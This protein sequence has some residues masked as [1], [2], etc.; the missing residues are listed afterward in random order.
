[1]GVVLEYSLYTGRG[2]VIVKKND[3]ILYNTTN[4]SRFEYSR[5]EY[6]LKMAFS[7]DSLS[8]NF[9]VGDVISVVDTTCNAYLNGIRFVVESIGL[10][11]LIARN[12]LGHKIEDFHSTCLTSGL[13]IKLTSHVKRLAQG[14][15]Q[16]NESDGK[17]HFRVHQFN[18]PF[19]PDD[20]VIVR[21]VVGN[22]SILN[23]VTMFV[24][25]IDSFDHFVLSHEP[26]I[27]VPGMY[28]YFGG[29]KVLKL[30]YTNS[31]LVEKIVRS[32][33]SHI[34]VHTNNLE[35]PHNYQS[36]DY[37]VLSGLFGIPSTL[38]QA[39]FVYKFQPTIRMQNDDGISLTLDA[40]HEHVE[41]YINYRETV[42]S[43]VES[44]NLT[45]NESMKILEIRIF[46]GI[47]ESH[48]T[49]SIAIIGLKTPEKPLSANSKIMSVKVH[50]ANTTFSMDQAEL[51]TRTGNAMFINR[52][53]QH[54]GTRHAL[55][56]DIAQE[57]VYTFAVGENLPI[58]TDVILCLP[59]FQKLTGSHINVTS[60]S[61]TNYD[62]SSMEFTVTT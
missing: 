59:D 33:N 57:L 37:V 30:D 6:G 28:P 31:I 26:P 27:E 51:S 3:A 5:F 52:L 58:G 2:K 19:V 12:K 44:F 61:G 15:E 56:K 11:W 24:S 47:I 17:T 9:V 22:A 54:N 38:M 46:S 45:W 8:S 7:I 53:H 21:D 43:G 4:I 36:G 34:I 20:E 42:C 1:M 41:P 35:G 14:F 50:I 48:E 55:T 16:F 10:S 23:G 49:C 29:M 25:R 40:F 18:H 60:S 39:S 62:I 32:S 13:I